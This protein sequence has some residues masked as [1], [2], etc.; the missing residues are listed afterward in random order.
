[1][2]LTN[3]EEPGGLGGPTPPC[4]VRRQTVGHTL[5]SFP[6]DVR[7]PRA[8]RQLDAWIRVLR[9]EVGLVPCIAYYVM[10][11]LVGID[12]VSNLFHI[13]EGEHRTR[14]G[15]TDTATRIIP[16]CQNAIFRN[17]ITL[18]KRVLETYRGPSTYFDLAYASRILSRVAKDEL[19]NVDPSDFIATRE[20]CRIC[21]FIADG[22]LSAT[23]SGEFMARRSACYI[24][25]SGDKYPFSKWTIW[26]KDHSDWSSLHKFIT[27]NRHDPDAFV[28][29]H[30]CQEPHL[31]VHMWETANDALAYMTL[32]IDNRMRDLTGGGLPCI[33]GRH[34]W[35]PIAWPIDGW[36]KGDQDHKL[37]GIFLRKYS[38]LYLAN[39]DPSQ[40]F[41]H[42]LH[43]CFKT[44]VMPVAQS[45]LAVLEAPVNESGTLFRS[46]DKVW[47]LNPSAMLNNVL[48]VRCL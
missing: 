46:E 30:S 12:T 34:P 24:S 47:S 10:T 48:G 37:R 31:H 28:G 43:M 15:L 29:A 40:E 7:S 26:S 20:S 17:W 38:V 6:C 16:N 39:D 32:A 42:A 4:V 5:G 19:R 41:L 11:D 22:D 45:V 14:V 13:R 36:Y 27:T 18:H 3:S 9:S 35:A 25:R 44:G 8:S 1:M 33:V 23:M 2:N 21:Q